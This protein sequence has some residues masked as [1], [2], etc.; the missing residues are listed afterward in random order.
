M[1]RVFSFRKHFFIKLCL[2]R[3]TQ[4]KR[5]GHSGASTRVSLRLARA[6]AC[7]AHSEQRSRLTWRFTLQ[8]C[9]KSCRCR[10][11][12]R[13]CTR[14]CVLSSAH[15][16]THAVINENRQRT[17][18]RVFGLSVCIYVFVFMM[19][20]SAFNDNNISRACVNTIEYT[21]TVRCL[22]HIYVR[23]WQ[24]KCSQ[25]KNDT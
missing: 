20:L 10:R 13:R 18:A 22:T 9:C 15:T 23:C 17:R 8:Q 4:A 16:Q 21:R 3:C 12:R 6:R 14:P 25:W 24:A 11:R 1:R 2:D 5:G 7:S 19:L